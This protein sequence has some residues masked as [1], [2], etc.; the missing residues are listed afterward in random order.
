VDYL[1]ANGG[2]CYYWEGGYGNLRGL[3]AYSTLGSG[4]VGYELAN[5]TLPNQHAYFDYLDIVGGKYGVWV[6]GGYGSSLANIDTYRV[7]MPALGQVYGGISGLKHDGCLLYFKAQKVHCPA[8][9]STG[10][11]VDITGGQGWIEID[12]VSGGG[13]ASGSDTAA[14]SIQG[15]AG[16]TRQFVRIREL[17]DV[18]MAASY[19]VL[20]TGGTVDLQIDDLT[21]TTSGDALLVVDVSSPILRLTGTSKINTAVNAVGYPIHVADASSV[22]INQG[23]LALIPHASSKAL[24]GDVAANVKNLGVMSAKY[25]K[26]TSITIQVGTLTVDIN[27]Q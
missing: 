10:A 19:L 27:V 6:F 5:D 21:R 17:T 7:W 1:Q 26:D 3:T 24:F 25:A 23:V 22:V 8:G 20:V 18:N 11:A 2:D 12:K 15:V 9:T 16:Q 4:F 13:N 14:L